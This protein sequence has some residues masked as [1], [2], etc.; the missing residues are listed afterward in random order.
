MISVR[1]CDHIEDVE[2]DTRLYLQRPQGA[3]WITE[4]KPYLYLFIYLLY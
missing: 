4:I 2:G 3:L 1:S